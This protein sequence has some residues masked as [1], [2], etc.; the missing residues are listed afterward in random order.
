MCHSA[1]TPVTDRPQLVSCVILVCSTQLE[2]C[3]GDF[4]D[5]DVGKKVRDEEDRKRFIHK[6]A[7]AA[8]AASGLAENLTPLRLKIMSLDDDLIGGD[9]GSGVPTAVG[10][11]PGGRGPKVTRHTD[12]ASEQYA[13]PYKAV[14]QARQERTLVEAFLRRYSRG[15]KG[16]YCRFGEDGMEGRYLIGGRF[17]GVYYRPVKVCSTCHMVYTLVDQARARAL[18]RMRGDGGRGGGKHRRLDRKFASSAPEVASFGSGDQSSSTA[19]LAAARPEADD[20]FE[21]SPQALSLAEARKAIDAVSQGDVSELRSFCR[22]PAAVVH[23]ASAAVALLDG[24]KS[25]DN[26]GLA[27]WT[28][29]RAALGSSDFFSRLQTL[30]PRT[31]T[32]CQLRALEPVLESPGFRPEAVRAFSNAAANMSLWVLGVVQANQWMMGRGHPRRNIVPAADDIIGWGKRTG[33]GRGRGGGCASVASFQEPALPAPVRRVEQE[34]PRRRRQ[35]SPSPWRTAGRK[36]RRF[37]IYAMKA[38][39][40]NNGLATSPML[41]RGTIGLDCSQDE[42]TVHATPTSQ[43]ERNCQDFRGA[44]QIRKGEILSLG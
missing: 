8:G 23:V 19:V 3:R 25:S 33:A 26:A 44:G 16:N 32:R 43:A 36:R 37:E 4:C 10:V 18:L 27:S 39:I 11:R 20:G 21:H 41:D 29:A 34:Q 28:H 1:S 30:D 31:L 12:T 5:F 40:E 24:I 6:A 14:V 35:G 2:G 15:E 17:P 38:R 42:S 9:L 22:P 13:I 7:R